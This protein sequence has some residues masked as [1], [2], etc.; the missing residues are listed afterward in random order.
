MIEVLDPG[1]LLTVQDLGRGGHAH[2]GVSHSGACDQA[3]ARRANA[4]VGNANSAAVLETTVSGAVLRIS[5]PAVVAVTGAEAEV[6][7]GDVP[8]PRNRPVRLGAG[9]VLEVGPA[10]AGMRNYIAVRGGIAADAP[11]GSRSTDTLSGLGPA[12]LKRGDRIQVGEAS[13]PGH[14]L[15]AGP[16]PAAPRIAGPHE[17]VTLTLEPGPR[18]DWI[19]DLGDVE[20]RVWEASADSNRIGL[21][22]TGEPLTWARDD[23]LVS[24]GLVA[25]AVQI[26][27]GG[28][29]VIFLAD[30]PTTGGYPV[31]GVLDAPSLARAAQV[32]PGQPVVLTLSGRD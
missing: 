30:H 31:V 5:Q 22:L 23:E 17:R 12:P 3:A 27:P 24:E 21:R 9:Q 6:F 10:G 7:V 11:L 25:G 4:A 14:D 1:L 20:R 19:R 29:P 15:F 26:P 16:F 13:A 32:R 2:L 8:A 28:Q 18:A